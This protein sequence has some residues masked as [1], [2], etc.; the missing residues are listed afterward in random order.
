VR[1]ASKAYW[2]PACSPPCSHLLPQRCTGGLHLRMSEDSTKPSLSALHPCL[3]CTKM[4]RK[5]HCPLGLTPL[6]PHKQEPA[7]IEE[8]AER[9]VRPQLREA[10]VGLCRGTVADYLARFGFKSDLLKVMYAVRS[11]ALCCAVL[12]CAALC[13][14]ASSAWD[15]VRSLHAGPVSV[16]DGTRLGWN[17]A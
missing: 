16:T 2:P 8:T 15:V 6:L 9:H 5:P 13:C 11:V 12:C 4:L 10:F 1:R 17:P 7:S 14:S 3:P